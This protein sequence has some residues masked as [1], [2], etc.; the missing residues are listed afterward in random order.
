MFIGKLKETTKKSQ[1]GRVLIGGNVEKCEEI[2]IYG[3]NN[4]DKTIKKGTI[5]F[6]NYAIGTKCIMEPITNIQY[7]EY[8]KS[9]NI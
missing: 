2:Y 4:S 9:S 7:G 6:I 8:V 5:V 3:Y 1:Y